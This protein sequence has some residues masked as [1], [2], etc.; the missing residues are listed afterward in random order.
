MSAP[1]PSTQSTVP[2]RANR[3]SRRTPMISRLVFAGLVLATLAAFVISQHLKVTT[4]FIAGLPHP[5]PA[6][7][8]PAGGSAACRSTTVSFFLLHHV[9]NVDVYVVNQGGS[10]VRSVVH[11]L[12]MRKKETRSFSWDGRNSAGQIVSPGSYFFR[13]Y[14]IHQ[15]RTIEIQQPV[16]VKSVATCS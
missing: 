3:Q 11:G 7:I 16:Q 8:D 6:T 5:Q 12:F 13:V 9:D 14:L 15:E 1:Q 2:T 4:P 10:T